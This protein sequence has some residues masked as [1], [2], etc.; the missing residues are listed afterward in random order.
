MQWL[1]HPPSCRCHVGWYTLMLSCRLFDHSK[2]H[3]DFYD[4]CNKWPLRFLVLW[5]LFRWCQVIAWMKPN[6]VSCCLILVRQKFQ[7]YMFLWFYRKNEL[8]HSSPSLLC[9]NKNIY[10]NFMDQVTY[11]LR[12]FNAFNAF[13]L[14]AECKG[15]LNRIDLLR[16][17][18]FVFSLSC[19]RNA[20][21]AGFLSCRAALVLCR[22][23]FQHVLT[24]MYLKLFKNEFVKFIPWDN[25]LDSC[26]YHEF[27]SYVEL[28]LYYWIKL[29]SDIFVNHLHGSF[30]VEATE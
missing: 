26:L 9:H 20:S 15:E 5:K 23:D 28:P 7:E 1:R 30:T 13:S 21:W 11:R 24:E 4:I 25:L 17:L 22:S 18:V 16:W 8:N 6:L 29:R 10:I 2:W 3:L 27:L 19:R 14:S 12:S